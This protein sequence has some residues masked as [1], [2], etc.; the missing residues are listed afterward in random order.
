M[1]IFVILLLI[2]VLN[3]RELILQWKIFKKNYYTEKYTT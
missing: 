1:A 2:R 3:I